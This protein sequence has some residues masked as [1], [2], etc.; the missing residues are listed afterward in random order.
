MKRILYPLLLLAPFLSLKA[1]KKLYISGTRL[2]R[3][4]VEKWADEYNKTQ[5]DVVIAWAGRDIPS[6]SVP[7]K[8]LAYYL[9]EK[10]LQAHQASIMIT[11]YLQLP[12]ANSKRPNLEQLQ[13]KGFTES[14]F[15]KVYFSTEPGLVAS[16]PAPLI[17]YKREKPACAAVAFAGHYGS[18]PNT[19]PGIGINGDDRDL[20]KA[21]KRDPNGISYNN[22]GF[23][24]DLATRKVADSLA[25]IPLDL[26][27]NGK[28]EADE[29]I[30][31]TLDEVI[32][33]AE[34]MNHPKLPI[35]GVNVVYNKNAKNA[36]E[37]KFLQWILTAGQQ[38]SHGYGFVKLT[39]EGLEAQKTLLA[40]SFHGSEK[41]CGGL[42]KVQ[43]KS[44]K[45]VQ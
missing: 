13:A 19:A 3:P 26:N 23:I 42:E 27:E 28:I 36:Q 6:D 41:S 15:R 17:V 34:K 45:S 21:V 30:Y 25:V 12:I 33:F 8:I 35:E 44:S 7:L 20:S 38:Y 40:S 5:S 11:R 39:A 43:R 37:A 32:E 31:G 14:D 1:Q 2:T 4:L 29:A 10:D 22:L 24:Y 18:N 9:T 16:G